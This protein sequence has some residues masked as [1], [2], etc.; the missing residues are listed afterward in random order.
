MSDGFLGVTRK[1]SIFAIQLEPAECNKHRYWTVKLTKQY[2]DS[3]VQTPV[4]NN[5]NII[6]HKNRVSEKLCWI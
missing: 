4:Y 1:W 3:D 5:N 6:N 2:I